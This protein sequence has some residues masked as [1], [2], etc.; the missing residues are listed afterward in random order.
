[1]EVNELIVLD[2][3]NG[4]PFDETQYL[5]K[6]ILE[7]DGYEYAVLVDDEYLDIDEALIMR[8]ELDENDEEILVEIEDDDEW[9]L[10]N[11]KLDEVIAEE[12]ESGY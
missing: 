2:D 12:N 7:I 5:L 10:V 3:E 4:Q 11:E 8:I 9:I 1:M 6:H